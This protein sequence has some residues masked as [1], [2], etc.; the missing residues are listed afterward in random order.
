MT[1]REAI[2]RL[3]REG[4]QEGPGNGSHLVFKLNGRRTVVSNHKGDIPMPTLRA[5]CKQAGREYPPKR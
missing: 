3:R 4:W 2:A 5:I 1:A